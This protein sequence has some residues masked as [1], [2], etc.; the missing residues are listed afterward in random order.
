MGRVRRYGERP[1]TVAV[2]HGGPGALG[3]AAFLAR[4]LSDEHGILEPLFDQPS[5][6]GQLNWLKE[7]L[8]IYG[9]ETCILMGHSWGAWLAWIFAAKYG[10]VDKVVLISSGPFEERYVSDMKY[11]LLERMDERQRQRYLELREKMAEK[12]KGLKEYSV[13]MME[14]GSYDLLRPRNEP[15]EVIR[16]VNEKVWAKAEKLRK[17]GELLEMSEDIDCP[18]LAIHGDHDPHPYEGVKEPLSDHLDDFKFIL[19][20][21]CGHYPWF[22]KKAREK[23]FRFLREELE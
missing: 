4:K 20:E 11:T 13:L 2:L 8:K 6:Q 23:F 10:R 18:I 1:Y 16:E 19:L 21:K 15:N 17:T 5:I 22:E 7:C 9:E 12:E 3:D 14:L